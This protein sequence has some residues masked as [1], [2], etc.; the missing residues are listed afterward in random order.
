M[1]KIAVAFLLLLIIFSIGC[2]Q[3]SKPGPGETSQE[4]KNTKSLD[5]YLPD[6]L[7]ATLWAESPMFYNPTNMDIDSKG[8]VWIT[9][10]VNYRNFNNDSTKFLHH[11]KG[12]RVMILEDTNGD[13]IADSSKVFVE[14][15]SLVS[16]LGI[17]VIGNK[18]IVSCSPNLIVYT[19]E[20]GDDIPDQKEIF[21]TG[22]GGK[23]H[24]HSLHAV[25]AGPDGNWYFNTGNAGPHI[26]TD[27]K[28][29]TL[30]SGSIYSGGSPYGKKNEGNMK[31]DDGKVWVGGLALS[32]KPNGSGLKV[33]GHNFRNAYE[34]TVDSYGNFWQNDNDDEVAAC[35]TS[36]L[37]EGANA[38]YFSTDGTRTWQADQ[39]P[40]QDIF[41]A[42]WHQEDPGVMPA[43]DCSGAGA[44]TGIVVNEGDNLGKDYRGMLLSADAGRNVIFGY[45]TK[46]ER[47]GYIPSERS[48]FISSLS[49]DTALYVWND[50]ASNSHHEKWFRPSDVAIGTDGAIYVADWYDPVVGGHQM[51]DKK[52]YGR[53]YRITPK[54]KTLHSPRIDLSNIA[55]Q[56]EALKNPAINVRNL[57]FN[58]LKKQGETV[59]DPVSALL[60][61]DNPY[62]QARAIWLLPQLGAKG[63]AATEQL[64]KNSDENIRAVAFRSL[65][66]C[67][68]DILPYAVQLQNDPSS[69]VRREI[70][71]A[72]RDLPFEKTKPVLL[73]LTRQYDGEDRWYL[74]AIGAALAGH[75]SAIYD[76]IKQAI[77]G[78][79]T[80]VQWDKKMSTLAWRLHPATA[81][82]DLLLR[83]IDSSLDAKERR[84]AITA[85]G[86]INDKKA[87]E[88]MLAL[89]ENKLTGTKEQASYWLSFRH[90]NNWYALLDWRKT[91]FNTGYERSFAVMKAKLKAV[92][93]EHI[94]T[95]ARKGR[96]A[97]MAKDSIGGQMLIGLASEN[98][99]PKAL[100]PFMEEIIFNNPDITVRVQAGKYFKQ[101]GGRKNYSIPEIAYLKGD[102]KSGATVF[103]TYCA[104][105]HK[106][107]QTGNNIGP[108]LT[109][110]GKKFDKTGLLDAIINPSA[111]VMAAY[112][113]WLI[114]TKDGE[115]FFGFIVSENKQAIIIKDV[116]GKIHPIP[117]DKISSK[118]KQ[119]KSL[120]PEP[121]LRG[122]TGQELADVVKFLQSGKE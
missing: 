42:H 20:N 16:P 103:T 13:G 8:R 88:A 82:N 113:P 106:R 119:S 89:R 101:P 93:D 3:S 1:K 4:K 81:L 31:S 63:I 121:G 59:I 110:I 96:L 18:V 91:N 108:E 22:F 73:E 86:F 10:A 53:I 114:N 75:E 100:T 34:F 111:A 65:R 2:T 23:D 15:T 39:R 17:A 32:I 6:D 83:A 24:D 49:Q 99:F 52:G 19:D 44:P 66:V 41:T 90:G 14:D 61:D 72:L 105:C 71:I 25:I 57:A 92:L 116:T 64:L 38:G 77:A 35:R 115:S 62:V 30:R 40:D 74:E 27:K 94:S 69:F 7:E 80:S 26:V 85:I 47:S 120:M 5:L 11:S 37:M 54:N 67:V 55:G 79:K 104:S 122:L 36:W 87:A 97:E 118:Q 29:W 117:L 68:A 9:E 84:S 28:G 12:D 107:G 76:E 21:L 60:K 95:D 48:D 46:S 45:R 109:T 51:L 43:G 58:E 78:I 70:A 102:E 50:S 56:I 98:K 33:L 112:E